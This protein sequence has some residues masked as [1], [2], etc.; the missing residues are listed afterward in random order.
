MKI[1]TYLL[2]ISCVSSSYGSF[3]YTVSDVYLNETLVLNSQSIL[4]EGGGVKNIV[5][6]GQSYIE[7]Q[8]T[9]IDGIGKIDLYNNSNSNISGGIV[10]GIGVFGV[11]TIK[12]DGGTIQN[13]GL[14]VSASGL[15]LCDTASAS[16][17]GGEIQRLNISENATA[18]VS[19]GDILKIASYQQS[20]EMKHIVFICDTSSVIY[21]GNTLTG[22]WLNGRDFTVALIDQSGYD[23]VYSN[24]QFIPEPATMLLLGVGGLWLR[25]RK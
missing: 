6:N 20:D 24:I 2:L 3:D 21:T 7:V 8:N 16:I 25:K 17:S 13:I 4:I 10:G 19:D 11:S 9:A 1:V 15:C 14:A 22:K 23:S 5:A 18:I 12:I